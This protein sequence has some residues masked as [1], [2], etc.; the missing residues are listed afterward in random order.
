[1]GF[2]NTVNVKGG[3]LAWLEKYGNEKIENGIA[4]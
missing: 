1:L 4:G 2:K 3:I